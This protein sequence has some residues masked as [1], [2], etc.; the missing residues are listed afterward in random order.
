MKVAVVF[1]CIALIAATQTAVVT[2]TRR[3]NFRWTPLKWKR[4]QYL[5]QNPQKNCQS[6]CH[7]TS[8]TTYAIPS[9]P[10]APFPPFC[11]F[12]RKVYGCNNVPP[13]S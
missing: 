11:D 7:M 2:R 5:L 6:P 4:F 10:N 12:C 9:C 3:S 13:M 8:P 1:M